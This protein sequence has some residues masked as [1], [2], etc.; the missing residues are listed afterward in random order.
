MTAEL[1]ANVEPPSAHPEGFGAAPVLPCSACWSVWERAVRLWYSL[2]DEALGLQE[3]GL[4]FWNNFGSWCF[5]APFMTTRNGED[6]NEHVAIG[7]P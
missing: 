4:L 6:I 7:K 1:G 3:L 5:T 2:K